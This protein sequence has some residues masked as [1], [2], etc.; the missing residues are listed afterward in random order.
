MISKGNESVTYK[1]PDGTVRRTLNGVDQTGAGN[2][3]RA[4]EHKPRDHGYPA[5]QGPPPPY[6]GPVYPQ[7]HSSQ[8][9]RDPRSGARL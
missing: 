4:I 5:P 9:H 8:S 7:P 6:D 3:P 2:T 1:L